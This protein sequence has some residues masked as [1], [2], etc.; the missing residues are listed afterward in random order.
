[1]N[2]KRFAQ[3]AETKAST[4]AVA[5]PY[6][7]IMLRDAA[8]RAKRDDIAILDIA[9]IVV[10]RLHGSGDQRKSSS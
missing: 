1:V 9:E 10:S 8:G 7:P 6:C 4:I 2:Q 5:C 3:L